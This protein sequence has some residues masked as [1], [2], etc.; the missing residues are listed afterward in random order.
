MPV[1]D[2]RT[3]LGLSTVQ[4]AEY[5]RIVVLE[6][7]LADRRLVIG[8]LADQ[9]FEVTPLDVGK[10]A[11]PPDIG[12]KRRSDYIRAIG[13]RGDSFVVVLNLSRLLSSH[14]AL[15]LDAANDTSVAERG[16]A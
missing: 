7:R 2:L 10:L 13:H 11:P 4:A 9:V 15:L 16:A 6:I 5:T 3:K 14:E 1:I 8:M 12:V